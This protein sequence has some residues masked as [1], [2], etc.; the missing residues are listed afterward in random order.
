MLVRTG[1]AHLLGHPAGDRHDHGLGAR[2][3]TALSSDPRHLVVRPLPE[4]REPAANVASADHC[5]LHFTP[6]SL[7]WL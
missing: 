4:I 3:V 6:S 7:Q 2:D 5:N 1:L